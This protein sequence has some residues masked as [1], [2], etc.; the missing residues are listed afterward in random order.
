MADDPRPAGPAQKWIVAAGDEEFEFPPEATPEMIRRWIARETGQVSGLIIVEKPAGA[1]STEFA[2]PKVDVDVAPGAAQRTGVQP[3]APRAEAPAQGP[4]W[5]SYLP[6]AGMVAATLGTDGAA[7]V[8]LLLRSALGAMTGAGAEHILNGK[9]ETPAELLGDVAWEGAK[10]AAMTGGLKAAQPVLQAGAR[11]ITR[12]LFGPGLNPRTADTLLREELL[13]GW[14]SSQ[15][16]ADTAVDDLVTT[17]REQLA[18]PVGR[19]RVTRLKNP[20]PPL[21]NTVRKGQEL[22]DVVDPSDAKGAVKGVVK[23]VSKGF[24]KR[25]PTVAGY[26]NRGI[27]TAWGDLEEVPGEVGGRSITSALRRDQ[28]AEQLGAAARVARG[29]SPET[30]D[31]LGRLRDL[32]P[33]TQRIAQRAGGGVDD[34]VT[35]GRPNVGKMRLFF[36]DVFSRAYG[37]T[38]RTL[39]G[40]SQA[41]PAKILG[42]MYGADAALGAISDD[43]VG[44]ISDAIGPDAQLREAFIDRLRGSGTTQKVR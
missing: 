5:T 17:A 18:G 40:L 33:A 39:Y 22:A 12:G 36:P 28:A 32:I 21:W 35:G 13:P 8:P 27:R 31:T 34:I 7:I 10:G 26:A 19:M 37:L 11:G 43:S 24:S 2:A 20:R 14:R 41:N 30:A 16:Y 9:D 15:H 42:G 44:P 1:A 6:A 4:G 23:G 38:G 3:D 29:R 25:S